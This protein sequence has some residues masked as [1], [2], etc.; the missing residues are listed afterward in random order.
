[1]TVHVRFFAS[2]REAVAAERLEVVI[3]RPVTVSGLLEAL[4]ERLSESALAALTAE[5]I[6]VAVNQELMSG[7]V[8]IRPG[9]EVAFLPPVTGG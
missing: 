3:E 9:D 1:M 7:A 6:R 8:E 5:S 4:G 2:L